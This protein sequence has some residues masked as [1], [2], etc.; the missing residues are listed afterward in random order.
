MYASIILSTPEKASFRAYIFHSTR[1]STQG[2][3][4]DAHLP[5]IPEAYIHI[6]R[7]LPIK[8]N[9]TSYFPV[10]WHHDHK[11]YTFG[12]Y[13]DLAPAQRHTPGNKEAELK[14]QVQVTTLVSHFQR[15]GDCMYTEYSLRHLNAQK[16]EQRLGNKVHDKENQN[17]TNL[18]YRS[19]TSRHFVQGRREE[20]ESCPSHREGE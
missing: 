20:R 16:H 10:S 17:T 11:L 13:L 9:P 8:S 2:P 15:I 19:T 5:H 7:A 1:F 6:Y 12:P 4:F 14:P 3:G 18:L